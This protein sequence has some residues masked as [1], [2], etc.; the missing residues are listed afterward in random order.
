MSRP[1]NRKDEDRRFAYGDR[2]SMAPTS[3]TE[4]SSSAA[5]STL[6]VDDL[7]VEGRWT[8]GITALYPLRR[9]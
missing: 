8:F 1:Q 9:P 2:G 7:L 5:V 6:A 4:T 3:T